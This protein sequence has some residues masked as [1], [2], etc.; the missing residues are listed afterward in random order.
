MQDASREISPNDPLHASVS[1]PHHH[2]LFPYGF[3]TQIKS[4]DP[5]VIR[6]AEISWGD[7]KQRFREAPI[8]VRFLVSE[9][10]SR[11]RPPYPV[12]RAQA[13]L[14]VMIADAHNFGCCDLV[15]G[16]GFACLTK[17]AVANRDYLRYHF[18]DAMVYILLEMQHLVALHAACVMKDGRGVLLVGESGAG[19]SSLA[20]ACTRRGW[21]Y[22]SDDS[23]SLPCRRSGR[24]VLGNPRAFR[25]RPS[26]TTLFP[27]LGGPTKARNGKPTVEIRTEDLPN[28]RT[29]DEGT[30]DFIVF[31]NRTDYENDAARLVPVSRED[32]LRRLCQNP[33][34]AE[35][36][37]HEERFQ[38]LER[39]LDAQCF[40]L[41]YTNLDPA[42][43]VLDLLVRRGDS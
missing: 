11:R 21:T 31:L 28:I 37:V 27:E 40:E 5:A 22:I 19:K 32:S 34:P 42:I 43:D 10:H 35:L 16:F 15:A 29:A 9:F 6:A 17:A 7:F 3:P 38:V 13:N 24:S 33:W 41:T 1:L 18:L 2:V 26:V 23:T 8:E 4:N 39:L 36:P 30:A 25:F 20:Y 14:L 12:F